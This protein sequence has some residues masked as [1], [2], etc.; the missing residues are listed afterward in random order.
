M[1]CRKLT[2]QLDAHLAGLQLDF[3][4][5][6]AQYVEKRHRIFVSRNPYIIVQ[7]KW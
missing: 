3:W 4:M 2:A 7:S 5:S 1:Y 6:H